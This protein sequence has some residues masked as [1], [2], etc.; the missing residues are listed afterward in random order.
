MT[1]A[2]ARRK[3]GVPDRSLADKERAASF[4]KNCG[5]LYKTAE[6]SGIPYSTILMWSK[7]PFWDEILKRIK[8]EDS[9]VLENTYTDIARKGQSVILDR[10]ENGDHV[11][12][13]EGEIIRKPVSLRDAT[14]AAAV[15]TDK[16]K[17]LS[18]Q[19]MFEQT[20]ST[21]ERLL[22][23]VEQFTKFTNKGKKEIIDVEVLDAIQ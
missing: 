2:V 7:K 19:P 22:K 1:Y 3:K 4:Y 12:T 20:L 10:L 18:E 11:L 14:L 23:L 8:K 5:S 17:I 6:L 13:K 16:R 15:A 9:V 21:N